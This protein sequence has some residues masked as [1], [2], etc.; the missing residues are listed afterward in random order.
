MIP[1][2]KL[3][4]EMLKSVPSLPFHHLVVSQLTQ[5]TQRTY[6]PASPAYCPRR[7]RS[8][9]LIIFFFGVGMENRA[10]GEMEIRSSLSPDSAARHRA[11]AIMGSDGDTERD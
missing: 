10:W 3:G 1:W 7:V 8:T 2:A 5:H 9:R 4:L 11:I 6:Y